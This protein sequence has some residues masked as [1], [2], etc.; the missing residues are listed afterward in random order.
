M[1][2]VIQVML[3]RVTH[4]AMGAEIDNIAEFEELAESPA[5]APTPIAAMLD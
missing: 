2:A 3:K 1:P 5:D 4:I